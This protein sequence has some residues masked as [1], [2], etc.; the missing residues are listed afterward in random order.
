MK[1][2]EI[3]SNDSSIHYQYH[4]SVEPDLK[5]GKSFANQ[6][7]TISYDGA[8]GNAG[9]DGN[10]IYTTLNLQYWAT[11]FFYEEVDDFPNN[12]YLVYVKNPSKG[13]I[14]A[15]HQDA[16]PPNEVIVLTKLGE[17]DLEDDNVPDYGKFQWLAQ[18]WIKNS[19][20]K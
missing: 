19:L 3:V 6:T 8:R 17:I 4:L 12:V 13:S 10:V 20:R 15:A 9:T 14:D 2:E 7:R 18:K 1:I 5:P 11:Q 16:S